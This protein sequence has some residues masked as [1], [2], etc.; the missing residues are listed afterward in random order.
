M[1]F[2]SLALAALLF[3]VVIGI[4]LGYLAAKRSN[5]SR[6]SSVVVGASNTEATC[7]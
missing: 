3:A 4:P 5:P 2:A 1:R 7:V 6:G